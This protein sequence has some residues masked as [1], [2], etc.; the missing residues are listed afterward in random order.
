MTKGSR[1]GCIALKKAIL[2]IDD[3]EESTFT[4]HVDGRTFHFQGRQLVGVSYNQKLWCNHNIAQNS[5]ERERWMQA[6]DTAIK[7]LLQ[8]VKVSS[9]QHRAMRA[10][11]LICMQRLELNLPLAKR[12][13]SVE[14]RLAICESYHDL[15]VEQ[16]Q[17]SQMCVLAK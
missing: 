11:I 3:E 7:R 6:L 14:N 16:I 17:V 9:Q 13:L 1:R 2:G 12:G 4:I 8:P 5:E 10:L 15:L